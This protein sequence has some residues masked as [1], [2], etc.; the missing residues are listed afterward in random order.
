[1]KSFNWLALFMMVASAYAGFFQ[2]LG[3]SIFKWNC[4]ST[5][6]PSTPLGSGL[7]PQPLESLDCDDDDDDT[8]S[9]SP[10]PAPTSLTTS[11]SPAPAPTSLTTSASPLPAPT[12]S[13]SS[14]PGPTTEVPTSAEPQPTSATPTDDCEEED[15]AQPSASS[16][17]GDSLKPWWQS[18][19]DWVG[20]LFGNKKR[21][22]VLM[23]I[24]PEV[25]RRANGAAADA[26]GVGAIALAVVALL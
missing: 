11:A 7:V 22:E 19:T 18:I 14:V 9:A 25:Y 6:T 1:M 2:D 20:G 24:L 5:S 13:A 26:A 8:T 3:C 16:T 21:D 23:F 15:Q 17:P 12:T 4:P 10:A